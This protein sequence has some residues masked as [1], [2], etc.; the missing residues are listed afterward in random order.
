MDVGGGSILAALVVAVR[1]CK[2]DDDF[3]RRRDKTGSGS[4]GGSI[5]SLYLLKKDRIVRKCYIDGVMDAPVGI[6][7]QR[8]FYPYRYERLQKKPNNK[9]GVLL[10]R[11]AEVS[12]N[13]P[14][15]I[16]H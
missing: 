3:G 13:H 16:F 14:Y 6:I 4:M 5:W 1:G 9:L 11:T 7:F 8:L 10:L 2:D 12:D 15:Q